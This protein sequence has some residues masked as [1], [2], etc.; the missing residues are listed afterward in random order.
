MEGSK[1]TRVLEESEGRQF[2]IGNV[3]SFGFLLSLEDFR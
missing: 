1:K 2:L 3:V